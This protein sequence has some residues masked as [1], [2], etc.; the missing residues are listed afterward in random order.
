[1]EYSSELESVVTAA[2]SS[3]AIVVVSISTSKVVVSSGITSVMEGPSV[4]DISSGLVVKVSGFSGLLVFG[5]SGEDL[6]VEASPLDVVG[7]R[8][9]KACSVEKSLG[10]F[11]GVVTSTVSSLTVVGFSVDCL[12]VMKT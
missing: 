9:A 3:K 12:F 2:T 11:S 10:S 4:V 6:F 7:G 8:S 1:M 5:C